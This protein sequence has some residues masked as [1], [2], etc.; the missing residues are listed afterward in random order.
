MKKTLFAIILG[1]AFMLP[2]AAQAV[3]D[4][5]TTNAKDAQVQAN[6]AGNPLTQFTGE[7]WVK[8]TPTEKEA[9]IFGID[10]A[11]AVEYFISK[12]PDLQKSRKKGVYSLSP[13]ERGWMKAFTNYSRKQIIKD[14]DDWYAAN[15]DKLDTP[16]MRVLWY[17]VVE[18][19]LSADAAK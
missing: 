14:V 15:P 2:A 3:Q 5:V 16:V 19:R 18:P 11:I 7:Y 17:H 9:F 8:S 6:P 4:D 13:F 10:T 12:N 1:I